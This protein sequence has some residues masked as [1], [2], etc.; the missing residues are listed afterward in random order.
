M[1]EAVPANQGSMLAVLGTRLKIIEDIIKSE[2]QECYIANDNSPQQVVISGLKNN[3]NSL[4]EILDKSKI[5]NIKLNVTNA[6]LR[7]VDFK[8]GLDKFLISAK[9]TKLSKKVKKLKASI[10]LKS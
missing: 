9:K 3:I 4:S 7:S 6:A 2:N 1:Q 10:S 8:G 5:K